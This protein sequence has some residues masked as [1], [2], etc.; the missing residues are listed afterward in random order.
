MRQAAA[1]SKKEIEEYRA[2]RE[3]K[4]RSVQPEVRV[5]VGAGV[6]VCGVGRCR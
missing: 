2:Q 5:C 1:E 6:C 4:L 3:A